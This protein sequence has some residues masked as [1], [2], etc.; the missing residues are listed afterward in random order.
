M[1]AV[2]ITI[3]QLRAYKDCGLL[4]RVAVLEARLGH[5][6]GENDAIPFS[7]WAEVIPDTAALIWALRACPEGAAVAVEVALRA[8]ERAL[9]YVGCAR[10]ECENAIKTARNYRAGAAHRSALR[11][12]YRAAYD[13]ARDAADTANYA[14][15]DATYAA[16]AAASATYAADASIAYTA[17]DAAIYVRTNAVDADTER[18][19]QR[20]DLL[21]LLTA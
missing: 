7:V 21:E 10:P 8:A 6:L 19:A 18:A 1:P 9:L 14:V 20:A 17:I 13:A 3:T 16:G 2:A 12:A 15:A 11:T 5:R 4:W